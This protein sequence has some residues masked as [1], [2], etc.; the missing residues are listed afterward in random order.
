MING[1]TLKLDKLPQYKAFSQP[2]T[3]TLDK[4]LMQRIV[5]LP[6]NHPFFNAKGT[7]AQQKRH[8]KDII[9][10]M[11]GDNL[12]VNSYRAKGLGRFYPQAGKDA[13]DYK[14]G[15]SIICLG[16]RIKH[17]ILKPLG[18][19]DID[20]C[21]AHPSILY[22]IAKANKRD[23][24]FPVLA[25]YTQDKRPI[26]DEI[27]TAYSLPENPLTDDDVKDL[28]SAFAYGGGFERW[29]QDPD[30][31]EVKTTNKIKIVA[32]FQAECRKG[33]DIVY[34]NNKAIADAIKEDGMDEWDVKKRVFSYWCGII[35]NDILFTIYK[36]LLKEGIAGD[37]L[38]AKEYDGLCFKPLKDFNENDVCE[39]LSALVF[40]DWK[41]KM[42]FKF[43]DYSEAFIFPEP[44]AVPVQDIV[45]QAEAV[46]ADDYDYCVTYDDYKHVFEKNHCKIVNKAFFIKEDDGKVIYMKKTDLLTAYEHLSFIVNTKKGEVNV[47]FISEWL[48]D[49]KCR[50]Y[51]DIGMYPPPLQCPRNVYNLWTPFRAQTLPAVDLELLSDEDREYVVTGAQMILD[52]IKV[53]CNHEKP[54]YDYVTEWIGQA[55]AFPAIK[56]TMPTFISEEGAGKGTL[57][58]AFKKLF[59]TSKIFTSANP[60]RDVW[61]NFNSLMA[62]CFIVCL[63]ELNP[64]SMDEAEGIIKNLLTE[65]EFTIN[66]KGHTPY[67]IRSFH[68]FIATTN[69]LIAKS[70]KDDR[71]N[72]YIRCSDELKGNSSYFTKINEVINDDRVIYILYEYLINIPN[73]ASFHKKPIPLT[74]YQATVQEATRDPLDIYLENLTYKYYKQDEVVL[75]STELYNM[76]LDWRDSNGIKYDTSVIKLVRNIGIMKIPR[77]AFITVAQDASLH[78]RDG[79]KIKFNVA[80]LKSHYKITKPP[81]EELIAEVA[82][83]PED[84]NEWDDGNV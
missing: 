76:F 69:S 35:E 7:F 56:T 84:E 60:S 15:M 40:K 36:Y 29:L 62:T 26:I 3:E 59:G 67:E 58:L 33:I 23:D 83:E 24:D 73:L 52:H 81:V 12:Y 54:V 18:W 79:N 9:T 28:L 80:L 72:A 77:G 39:S 10:R 4:A 8:L 61:G 5:A 11:D 64:R 1:W 47:G 2:W 70:K 46:P 43:K 41:F 78:T 6:D 45:V 25:R 16:R 82:D 20:M 13:E 65:D 14:K 50:K 68:R 37:K 27:K 34:N 55:L 49:G 53:L 22:G 48:K 63:D 31:P 42:L 30:I 75:K 19:R 17:S 21:A 71:R 32:D 57:M 66:P 44:E 74:E 51:E 38:G